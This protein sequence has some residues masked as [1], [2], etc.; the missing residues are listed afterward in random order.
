[1]CDEEA[2]VQLQERYNAYNSHSQSYTWKH[3][4]NLLDMGKTLAENGVPDLADEFYE[5]SIDQHEFVPE[6]QVYFNDDL[7]PP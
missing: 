4:G 1:M 7:T 2:L 6:L 5:L 3:L